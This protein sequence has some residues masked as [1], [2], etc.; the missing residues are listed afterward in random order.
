MCM[1]CVGAVGTAFQAATLIGGPIAAKHYQR[2]R[3]AFGL[4]DNSVAAVEAREQQ[5]AG[6]AI[7]AP[8]ASRRR[9]A[10][11]GQPIREPKPC[12]TSAVA[13]RPPALVAFSASPTS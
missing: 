7:T 11:L 3:A 10:G 13:R 1:Q 2:I 6:A 5:G 4:Q 8:V 9:S 12:T